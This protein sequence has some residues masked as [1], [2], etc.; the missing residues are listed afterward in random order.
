MVRQR[1]RLS[2]LVAGARDRVGFVGG[3]LLSLLRGFALGGLLV[4]VVLLTETSL[5]RYT[6][7]NLFPSIALTP[8]LGAFPALAAQV[9]ASLLGFYLAS[10]SIVLGNAYHDVSA[11][12]R[13]LVLGNSRTRLYVASIGM[14]IGSGLFLLLLPSLGLPYGYLTSIAYV[15]LVVFSG[16]AFVQ[17]A[18]G[19]FNLFNPVVLAEEPLQRLYKAIARLDSKGLLRDEAVLKAASEDANRSLGILS[20]LIDLASKRGSV[21]RNGL[22]GMV[23]V[24]LFQIRMYAQKKHLLP[25]TS[26]WFPREPTYPKWVETGYTETKIALETSTPLPARREPVTDWLERRTAETAS[27]ALET[28]VRANDRDAALRLVDAI[29]TTVHTFARCYRIDDATAFAEVVRDRCWSLTCENKTSIVVAAC[30]PLTLSNILLGWRDAIAAWGDEI[31]EAVTSTDWDCPGTPAVRIRGPEHVWTTAQRLLRETQTEQELDGRRTTPDWYLHFALANACI[32]SIR[33]FAKQLP[34][35]LNG[36]LLGPQQSSP[37]VRAATGGQDLQA[38]AKAELLIHS[39]SQSAETLEQLKRG[40]DPDPI[41]ELDSLAAELRTLRSSVLKSISDALVELPPMHPSSEPD[42]F[43]QSLF[44]LEHHIGRAVESGDTELVSQVFPNVLAASTVMEG[45]LLSTYD[46]TLNEFHPAL[47]DPTVD[48]LELSGLAILYE[49][50]RGDSSAEPVRRAW[51]EH[52]ACSTQSKARAIRILDVLDLVDVSMVWMQTQRNMAR[53]QWEQQLADRIIEAGYASP[54]DSQFP[55]P[56]A[57]NAPLL[58]KIFGVSGTL[59]MVSLSP[60][61]IFAATV[62]GPMTGE[63]ESTL[64]QRPSLERYYEALDRHSSS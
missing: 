44:T 10:V 7:L 41:K 6:G 57:W 54:E 18:F 61:T 5:A 3:S 21:D 2:S 52:L 29:A 58:I 15:F 23:E 59:Q 62:V 22:V 26:A 19:A 42:T 17:L 39:I 9:S 56:Q 13:A 11:D 43:G 50:L 8:S 31:R 47:L 48:L 27:S 36:F 1:F 16:W 35:L 45:H 63:S 4:A 30:P 38:I 32:F 25:P 14:S 34:K 33:E 40:H 12:V 24:L 20:H 51:H 55:D 60:R 37:A 53:T 49:V 28:C 64:R 46:R